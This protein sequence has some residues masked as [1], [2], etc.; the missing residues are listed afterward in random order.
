MRIGTDQQH[1]LSCVGKLNRR[2]AGNRSL[3]HAAFAGEEEETRGLFEELH[4]GASAFLA[5]A[6]AGAATISGF[7][8]G[9][10]LRDACPAGQ[11][12]TVGVAAGQGDFAINENQR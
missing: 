1:A 6:T 2:R 12:R 9:G 3:A 10:G 11:L 8:F 4:G 5:A 7:G